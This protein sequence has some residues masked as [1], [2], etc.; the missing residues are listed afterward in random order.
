METGSIM[1][2]PWAIA[3]LAL[4]RW[5]RA[6]GFSAVASLLLALLWL[7]WLQPLQQTSVRLRQQIQE[8]AERYHH[9]LQPLLALPSLSLLEQQLARAQLPADAEKREFLSI[10]ALL[11]ARGA[12]LERWQPGE[13]G[14]ELMLSLSW[15]QFTQLLNDLTAGQR[16][17]TIPALTLQGEAPRL[18]LLMELNDES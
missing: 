15:R 5:Q 17:V 16:S 12:E 4:S 14:G 11:T 18:Q 9:Q 10:P 1:N 6:L 13:R 3:W 7:L 8:N 2:N